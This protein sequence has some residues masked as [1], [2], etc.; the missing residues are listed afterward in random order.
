MFRDH[1]LGESEFLEGLARHD[2]GGHLGE[3]DSDRLADEGG[4]PGGAGIHLEHVDFLVLDGVL[5]VH[6]A[7]HIEFQRHRLGGVA[8]GLEDL[9]G[10]RDARQHAGAVA[11]VDS[12]LLDMLHDA[13]DDALLAVGKAVDID[14]GG[15]LQE[16]VHENRALGTDFYGSPDIP[17]EI[18][19]G[20]DDLHGASTEDEG[21]TDED[22][23][24]DLIGDR[25]GFGFTGGG[26]ARGLAQL[27]LVDHRGEVLPVLRHLDALGLGAD[28]GHAAGLQMGGEVERGLSAELDDGRVALLALV[29][30]EDVLEGEGLEEELV[31]GVVIGRDGLRVGV[32]HDGLEALL[33][34]REGG[35][36]AAV[37]ELD[38]LTDAVGPSAEDHHLLLRSLAGLILVAVGGVEIGG[39]RLELRR[40]GV[41]QSVGGVDALALPLLADGVLGRS[42]DVGELAVGEAELLRLAKGDVG[43]I[44]AECLLL[45]DEFLDVVEEPR[46][47]G[48]DLV[49]L[50]GGEP[51][52]EGVTHGED[53][54]G[55]RRAQQELD[56]V[57]VPAAVGVARLQV[58]G[59]A[60]E[61]GAAGLKRAEG[62][63]ECLLEGASDRHRL[64]DALHLTGEGRIRFRE[65]LE[66]EAR[67]LHHAVVDRRLE[68]G[69]RRP[70]DVVLEF[71]EAVANGQL[72][73]DLRDR[74]AG[75]LRGEG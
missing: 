62:F 29:D 42:G 10:K 37:V 59:I 1:L 18:L 40:A 69:G 68:A 21:G 19:L 27:Q 5:D 74:V 25:D 47:D 23:V 7:A 8:D 14:L 52:E 15:I 36:N 50:F 55:V 44:L 2:L 3:G 75:R 20:V 67:D 38:S 56:P 34:Q 65:F 72:G 66:G 39:R 49:D 30:V 28:D 4:G 71:V 9:G 26:A 46:V 13:S 51:C 53:A 16:A 43:G 48:A 33:L 31:A 64:A 32:H 70:G 60:A 24:A 11:A 41:D 22:G 57:G 61:S 63:L 54:L 45:L 12:G 17:A 35:M 73:G 58:L 6:Q